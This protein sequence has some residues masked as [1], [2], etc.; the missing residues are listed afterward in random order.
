LNKEYSQLNYN[1]KK[2]VATSKGA[3]VD[4]FQ[5]SADI[6]GEIMCVSVNTKLK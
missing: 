4:R 1:L 5:I 3:T 6:Q 2:E